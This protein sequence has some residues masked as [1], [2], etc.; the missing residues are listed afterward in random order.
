MK[1]STMALARPERDKAPQRIV[2]R[3]AHRH[4]ISR[5]HL[6]TEAAHAAAQLRENLVA[7]VTL[8]PIQAAAVH[9]DHRGLHVDQIVFAH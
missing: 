9:R 1:L 6:D 4:A 5:H 3:N 7:G 2:W 8:Y